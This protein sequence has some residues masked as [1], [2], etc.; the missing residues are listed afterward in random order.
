M[1]SSEEYS[2]LVD[3]ITDQTR[4]HYLGSLAIQECRDV[5]VS[6]TTT[7]TRRA[8]MDRP[9]E[10]AALKFNADIVNPA[11]ALLQSVRALQQHVDIHYGSIGDFLT[12]NNIFVSEDF[13]DLSALV[14][15]TISSDRIV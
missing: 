5:L 9:L 15:Y 12:A 7:A 10:D 1:I 4:A 13:A 2:S 3:L 14:G 8:F 6:I 11:P